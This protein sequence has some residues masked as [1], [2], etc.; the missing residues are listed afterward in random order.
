MSWEKIHFK[1]NMVLVI[2]KFVVHSNLTLKIKLGKKK[3]R[4]SCTKVITCKKPKTTRVVRCAFRT[5]GVGCRAR[6][7]CISMFVGAKL[8]SKKCR[9]LRKSCPLKKR[10]RCEKKI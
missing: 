7:C 5:R 9:V 6:K 3:V 10:L 8:A 1:K 4:S 2:K